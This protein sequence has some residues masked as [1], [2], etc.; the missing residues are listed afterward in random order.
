MNPH[1]VKSALAHER[2]THVRNRA[3]LSD[4]EFIQGSR[5]AL[6]QEKAGRGV[7]LKEVLDKFRNDR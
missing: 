3:I 2:K 5:I 7:P 1:E 4:R 6:K